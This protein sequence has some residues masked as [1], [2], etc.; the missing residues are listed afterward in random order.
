M[1]GYA[2]VDG[3]LADTRWTWEIKTVNGKGL[4]IR[5]RMPAGAER[6]D[7]EVRRRGAAVLR[8]G[9]VSISLLVT[10]NQS[11]QRPVVNHALLDQILSLQAELKDLVSDRKPTIENLLQVRGLIELSD[12]EEDEQATQTRDTAMMASLDEALAVA[13][14]VRD[15]EGERLQQVLIGQLGRVGELV[16]AASTT[17]AVQPEALRAR[18]ASQVQQ[19]LESVPALPEEKLL[20]E[21]AVLA[22]KADIREELDRL[23]AH[24]MAAND[25]IAKDEPVGR[26]LEFLCQEFNREA[27]TLCAKSSDIDLT[28][29]GL[30]LK[31]VI[32]QMRE[33]V[34]NVE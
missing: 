25:L 19:L 8:R 10:K 22:A 26:R 1:T 33:Q 11:A 2:R 12:A 31:A 7:A 32:D 14:A 6:M 29:I 24:I 17:A 15:A 16:A 27:N 18:L 30:D 3:H 5:C 28:T 23:N 20:Q 21:A 13:V 34:Q 4:D 9:N